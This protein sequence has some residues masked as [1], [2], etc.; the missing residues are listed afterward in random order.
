MFDWI[1]AY[2]LE[3]HTGS[4]SYVPES[5]F[6]YQVV[7]RD[8]AARNILVGKD[9]KMKVADFGLTRQTCHDYYRKTTSVSEPVDISDT[10]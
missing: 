2:S 10:K 7:H 8:L 9:F 4:L 5:I 1:C 6:L 3:A